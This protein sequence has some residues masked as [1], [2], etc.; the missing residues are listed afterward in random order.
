MQSIETDFFFAGK[1]HEAALYAAFAKRV[2]ELGRI[3]IR[4]KKTQISLVN[5]RTFACV[6]MR[7][8]G[9]LIITFG[10]PHCIAS[11]R[12]WQAA[13]PYPNRWTHHVVVERQE[14]IDDELMEW[15][16]AAYLFA[17]MS[18]IAETS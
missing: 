15:M 6:S 7:R 4:V 1:T 9:A 3:E 8:K 14:E 16:E 13:E 17:G 12:I 5:K 11:D 2:E 18:G 10:L